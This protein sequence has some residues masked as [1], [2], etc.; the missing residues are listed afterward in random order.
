MVAREALLRRMYGDHPY[1]RELPT[2]R[3][4]RRRSRPAQLRAL[5]AER[6]APARQRARRS[7]ATST[8]GTR[9]R[10]WSSRRWPAGPRRRA[11]VRRPAAAAARPAGALLVDRPGAVQSTLRLAGPAP[12]RTDPDYAAFT[13]A[14][15]VFGGYFSSRWVAN[16]RE[17]KG[18]TYSPHSASST[19]RPA[20]AV[21]GRPT[22]PRGDGAG[23][24]RDPVR[25]GPRSPPCRSAQAELDQARRYA[26]GS[27]ALSTASQAGLASTLSA[28]DGERARRRVAARLAAGAGRRSP[29]SEVLAAAARYLA[30]TAA[31]RRPGRRRRAGRGARSSRVLPGR[32]G[33]RDPAGAAR[34]RAADAST[35]TP[36]PART[37]PRWP[38]PGSARGCSWS[39]TAARSSTAPRSCSSAPGER[40]GGRPALPRARRTGSRSS[41]SPGRCPAGSA[42]RA[43]G[44]ATSA[45]V[46]DDRDAGLLTHAVGLANWHAAHPRCPRCGAPDPAARRL[47][48]AS[49]PRTAARTSRAPTRPSSCWSPT[50]PTGRCSAGRPVWPPRR[51]STLA[52]FVEPGESAEQAVVREVGEEAGIDVRAVVYRDSQPWPFPRQ[53]DARLP[54]GLRRRGRAGAAGRRARGRPLVHP[55]ASCA[56]P[57][58]GQAAAGPCCCRRRCRSPTG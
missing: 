36:R 28:L 8:P 45:R 21:A 52:G 2:G 14:N 40:P 30:P 53:P 44:C 9:P 7:S 15:L 57:A 56:P 32:A 19:R 16:I 43:S 27:L 17:D 58:T 24:A 55:R 20:R 38:P 39:R 31:H 50:A 22:S 48:A 3:G 11:A 5:H 49:A 13:L 47:G 4:G 54:R 41:R 35:A 23:A 51:Y 18:Y 26:I 33:R 25:A 34:A 6:V 29:S 12:R 46:L 37:T 10:R 42:P 1:G